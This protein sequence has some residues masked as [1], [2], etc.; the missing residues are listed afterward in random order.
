MEQYP[1]L[2][3]IVERGEILALVVAVLPAMGGIAVTLLGAHW[4]AAAAG[5]LVAGVVFVL[6]RSY[7]ELVRVIADMLIPK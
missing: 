5:L 1:T 2:K 6:L 4:V 3:L 7:V